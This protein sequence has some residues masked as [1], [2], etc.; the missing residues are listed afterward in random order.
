MNNKQK[1]KITN[2]A[3]MPSGELGP[4]FER[5]IGAVWILSILYFLVLGILFWDAFTNR[6]LYFINFFA[7]TAYFSII[8]FSIRGNS[9]NEGKLITIVLVFNLCF[10]AAYNYLFFLDRGDFLAFAAADSETYHYI[11]DYISRG[12]IKDT[13][14]R[15]PWY[16]AND[17]KGFVVYASLLYRIIPSNLILNLFNI[18]LNLATTVILYKLGRFILSDKGAF[19]TAIIYGVATYTVFY[20]ASG[21]KETLMVFLTV[22]S[23]YYLIQSFEKGSLPLFLLGILFCVLVTFFRVPVAFFV[24]ASLGVYLVFKKKRHSILGPVIFIILVIIGMLFYVSFQEY[25]SRYLFSFMDV[26]FGKEA[27][28]EHDM[29]FAGAVAVIS[30]IF[31]PFPTLIPFPGK[32]NISIL[33]GSL[34]LKVLISAYFVV[35]TYFAYKARNAI[36]LALGAF[37]LMEIG[38]LIYLL[39]SFEFRLNFPHIGFFVLITIYGF[40]KLETSQLKYQ[41]LKK[42][43]FTGNLALVGAIYAWN[44]LRF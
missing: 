39:E 12:P 8:F 31:G 1:P 42:L 38:G 19:L 18:I 5:L 3:T 44:I 26:I 30:G 28:F 14:S 22:G 24:L 33:A 29:R 23:L 11:A 17:D 27:V 34:I 41:G 16:L 20:Q 15:F 25:L 40:E 32:E 10:V 37:C 4:E 7:T 43:I 9:F 6:S 36:A 35:G 13:L 2:S 21:L